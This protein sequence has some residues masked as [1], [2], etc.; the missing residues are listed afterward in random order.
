MSSTLVQGYGFVYWK[1]MHTNKQTEFYNY[2]QY[3]NKNTTQLQRSSNGYH[4]FRSRRKK[5]R[6]TC[7]SLFASTYFK[8]SLLGLLFNYNLIFFLFAYLSSLVPFCVSFILL[9]LSIPLSLEH[10]CS[11][12][13][14]SRTFRTNNQFLMSLKMLWLALRITIIDRKQ[15][16]IYIKK[17]NGIPKKQR[18]I[19]VTKCRRCYPRDFVC[20]GNFRLLSVFSV[21]WNSGRI[22]ELLRKHNGIRFLLVSSA[23]FHWWE[24]LEAKRGRREVRV[25]RLGG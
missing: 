8:Y 15:K 3:D 14:T 21:L 13:K 20:L 11:Y 25:K 1:N 22:S 12:E 19:V 18:W 16:Y 23:Y 5:R 4:E 2:L 24:R 9:S 6:D 7:F 10:K 17:A